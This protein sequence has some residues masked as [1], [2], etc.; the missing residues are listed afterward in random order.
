[1]NLSVLARTEDTPARRNSSV[2]A[3]SQVGV[4]RSDA[5]TCPQN[6]SI[7]GEIGIDSPPKIVNAHAHRSRT[8]TELRGQA[9]MSREINKWCDNASVIVALVWRTAELVAMTSI[10][11]G[12]L[13]QQSMMKRRSPQQRRYQ[14]LRDDL[15]DRC[16]VINSK[17]LCGYQ[18]GWYG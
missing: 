6:T 17:I 16:Q 18:R 13:W 8:P 3:V 14:R 2:G 10:Q 9:G 5:G 4:N 7:G 1:V 12:N 15:V 11:R